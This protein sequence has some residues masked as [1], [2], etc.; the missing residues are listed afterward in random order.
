MS[1]RER[2]RERDDIIRKNYD[3]DDYQ[4]NERKESEK[5]ERYKMSYLRE[6]EDKIESLLIGACLECNN[7]NKCERLRKL[8]SCLCRLLL[9]ITIRHLFA[10]S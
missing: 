8:I 7:N 2:E 10:R 9:F 3:D 6:R 1:N 4:R 5:G